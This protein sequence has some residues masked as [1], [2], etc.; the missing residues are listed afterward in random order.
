MKNRYNFSR[1]GAGTQS[2]AIYHEDLEEHEGFRGRS[3]EPRNTP[4]TQKNYLLRSGL[5]RYFIVGK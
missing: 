4:N 5:L 2:K 3:I 1:S